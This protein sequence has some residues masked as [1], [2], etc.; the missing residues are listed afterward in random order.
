MYHC[1]T[2]CASSTAISF[3]FSWYIVD[4]NISRHCVLARSISGLPYTKSYD[5][6]SISVF[7]IASLPMNVALK[8]SFVNFITLFGHNIN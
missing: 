8:P 3:N 6:R 4:F 5:P 7:S 1:K 2:V